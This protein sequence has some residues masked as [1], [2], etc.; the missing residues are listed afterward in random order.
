MNP[1]RSRPGGA[2]LPLVEMGTKTRNPFLRARSAFE[3]GPVSEI[4]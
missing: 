3:F 4:R 1:V 2:G